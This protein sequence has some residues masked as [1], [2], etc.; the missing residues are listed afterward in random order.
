MVL[1][2]MRVMRSV[3]R[4][5]LPSRSS[6]RARMALSWSTWFRDS[7]GARIKSFLT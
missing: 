5:P 4:I 7:V 1:R 2:S 6:R 3:E